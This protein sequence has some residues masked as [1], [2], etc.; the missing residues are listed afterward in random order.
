MARARRSTLD[1]HCRRSSAGRFEPI[2][3]VFTGDDA[4]ETQDNNIWLPQEVKTPRAVVQVARRNG[5]EGGGFGHAG[6]VHPIAH[7]KAPMAII[8]PLIVASCAGSD[9]PTTNMAI[10]RKKNRTMIHHQ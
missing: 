2:E 1:I 9:T 3:L 10:P 4:F 5:V 6:G 7:S 8:Q